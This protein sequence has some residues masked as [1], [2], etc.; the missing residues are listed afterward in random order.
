MQ[1]VTVTF[2]PMG[3]FVKADEISAGD[4]FFDN[5]KVE[6]TLIVDNLSSGALNIIQV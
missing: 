4:C 3:R 1:S 6:G 2:A 5:A